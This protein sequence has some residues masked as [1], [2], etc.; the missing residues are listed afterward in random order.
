MYELFILFTFIFI[1]CTF[2][3]CYMLTKSI[4]Y[5]RNEFKELNNIKEDLINEF[6]IQ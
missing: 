2:I 1:A 4:K 5:I 3:V 6:K